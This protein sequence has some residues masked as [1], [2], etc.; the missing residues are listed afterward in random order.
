M[1]L[2]VMTTLTSNDKARLHAA[3]HCCCWKS[4]MTSKIRVA[5]YVT[6]W[7]PSIVI[8]S[9]GINSSDT[10]YFNSA[11]LK[12]IKV[13]ALSTKTWRAVDQCRSGRKT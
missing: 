12:T 7:Q 10:S 9:T 6:K 1:D 8:I 3:A 11:T 4:Q 2:M 13:V 5:Y